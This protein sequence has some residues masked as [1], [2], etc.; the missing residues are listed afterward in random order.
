MGR[1]LHIF[2]HFKKL[3]RTLLLVNLVKNIKEAYVIA[4]TNEIVFV[5]LGV[6]WAKI[7]NHRLAHLCHPKTVKIAV[8]IDCEG[9]FIRQRK[10]SD[11]GFTYLKASA[12]SA[13]IGQKIYPEYA[14]L[15][16]HRMLNLTDVHDYRVTGNR[17]NRDML[18]VACFNDTCLKLCHFSSAAHHGNACIVDH[19]D[20]IAAMLANIKLVI[21]HNKTPLYVLGY[22]ISKL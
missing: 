3:G 21:T 6:K 9:L 17:S 13:L 18:L 8:C 10:G 2:K 4:L 7:A 20:Q 11:G 19:S 12:M 15:L 5:R 1:V 22:R 14:V 16:G